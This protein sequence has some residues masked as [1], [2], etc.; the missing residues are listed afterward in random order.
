MHAHNTPI[1]KT[2]AKA[3]ESA[4]TIFYDTEVRCIRRGSSQSFSVNVIS[5]G[6][7]VGINCGAVIVATGFEVP[8]RPERI[9][10]I[11][12]TLS[13]G[14]VP[15]P[16]DLQTL[17]GQKVAVLGLGNSAFETANSLAEYVDYVHVVR[18]P[19]LT[20]ACDQCW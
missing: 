18:L 20:L 1:L 8:N 10:G 17:S 4:G 12:L 13:Y 16:A 19:G 11:N 7:E 6:R 9:R 3:Q 15:L 2:D 14:D 5:H